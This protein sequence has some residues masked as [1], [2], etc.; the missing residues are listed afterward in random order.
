MVDEQPVATPAQ[1]VRN[2]AIETHFAA[3]NA[4]IV[5]A[6]T[7]QLVPAREDRD[8]RRIPRQTRWGEPGPVVAHRERPRAVANPERSCAT[9]REAG[10]G[11]RASG[12]KRAAVPTG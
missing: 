7:A 10:R 5:R 12:K 9:D 11:S 3:R 2:P 6:R 4:N 8:R 1:A